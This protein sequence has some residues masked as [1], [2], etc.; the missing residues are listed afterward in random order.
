MVDVLETMLE[1]VV[2]NDMAKGGLFSVPVPRDVFPE[3][4]IVVKHPMDYGTLKIKSIEGRIPF[5]SSNAERFFISYA[6]FLRIQC[7]RFR[8][9]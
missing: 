5:S 7:T 1:E 3:Y 2:N 4:S 8:H 6:N 9:S